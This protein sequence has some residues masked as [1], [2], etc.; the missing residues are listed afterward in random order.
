[1]DPHNRGMFRNAVR[2]NKRS[3]FELFGQKPPTHR[4]RRGEA[5]DGK[6]L[7]RRRL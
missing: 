7:P 3:D 4:K 6:Q 2:V 5:K 1:M